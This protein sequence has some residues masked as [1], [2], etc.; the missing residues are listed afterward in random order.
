M[1]DSKALQP[2]HPAGHLDVPGEQ[3][4]PDLLLRLHPHRVL[5]QLLQVVL[6]VALL[7]ELLDHEVAF[8]VF[9]CEGKELD[10]VGMVELF[11]GCDLVEKL[12]QCLLALLF[13][14]SLQLL[15]SHLQ[16]SSEHRFVHVPKL[17]RPDFGT[18]TKKIVKNIL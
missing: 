14:V 18:F 4:A 10:E 1:N 3:L 7:H 6:Q 5:L 15:G 8:S 9:S 2:F 13:I 16:V 17:T 12:L 11:H